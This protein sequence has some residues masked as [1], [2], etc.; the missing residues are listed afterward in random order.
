MI[1]DLAV[2]AGWPDNVKR[3]LVA[4]RTAIV[5]Q[6]AAFS[7]PRYDA[8]IYALRDS[9]SDHSLV[10]YHCTKL[11]AHEVEHIRSEGMSLLGAAL[12]ESRIERAVE[13]GF[14]S[15]AQAERLAARHN[16]EDEYRVGR[17]WFVF[18]EPTGPAKVASARCW[19]SGAA[20]LCI[21]ITTA[22]GS[23]DR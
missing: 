12:I 20:R 19:G 11:L 13:H 8:A 9:L 3:V 14:L 6:G 1:I 21:G 7:G 4:H 17:L 10:G 23:L 2:P 5:A 16:A 22:I 15:P 18:F